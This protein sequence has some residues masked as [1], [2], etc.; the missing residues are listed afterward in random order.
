MIGQQIKEHLQRLDPSLKVEKPLENYD[1]ITLDDEDLRKAREEKFYRLEREKYMQGLNGSK[2]SKSFTAEEYY[3]AFT[4]LFPIDKKAEKEYNLIVAVLCCY[5]SNDKRFET[6]DLKLR[7][8]ILLYGGVGVGKTTL[9]QAFRQNQAFSYR[10]ISCREVEGHFATEG[11]EAIKRYSI[12]YPV[13]VNSNR[14]GHQEIGYCFDDLGTENS[15]TKNYG[16]AK[17]VMTDILLNRYDS[18]LD[19]RSTH[20]TTNLSGDEIEKTYGTRVMDRITEN[21][22]LITFPVKAKSKR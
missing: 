1:Q 20:I 21:F 18:G 16:N 8:G 17:N 13:A 3:K 7:K 9:M 6:A 11:E 10:I 12:N 14:Y 22:N 19:P 5:F 15:N 2:P 4:Q